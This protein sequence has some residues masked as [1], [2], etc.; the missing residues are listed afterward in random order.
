MGLILLPTDSS[1][2]DH[3]SIAIFSINYEFSNGM[4]TK[5]VFSFKYDF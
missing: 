2:N 5:K 3:A 4:V 1:F